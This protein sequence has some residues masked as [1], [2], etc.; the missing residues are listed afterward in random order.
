MKLL[1]SSQKINLTELARKFNVRPNNNA[2]N[3]LG[4]RVV[5]EFLQ[6]NG[7]DL[8]R[9]ANDWREGDQLRRG[10]VKMPGSTGVSF[11]TPRPPEKLCEALKE[12][13]ESGKF[14][15]EN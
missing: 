13:I 6:D 12:G 7:E 11:A 5:K 3:N 9:F 4:G 1:P 10:T 14:H 15:G 2:K 8:S